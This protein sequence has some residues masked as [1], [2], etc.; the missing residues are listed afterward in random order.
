MEIRGRL[1]MA[2]ACAAGLVVAACSGSSPRASSTG[3]PSPQSA[4]SV[5][6]TQGSPTSAAPRASATTGLGADLCTIAVLS[7]TLGTNGAAAGTEYQQLLFRNIGASPCAL[8]GYPGVS[9]TD[10]AGRQ[11]GPAAARSN[12]TGQAITAVVLGAHEYAN[13]AVGIPTA[14]DYPAANC[15]PVATT[16]LRVFPPGSF[17]S[18]VVAFK[19]TVC[20]TGQ[21]KAL[22]TPVRAGRSSTAVG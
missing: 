22:V 19:T 13:A 17:Q 1:G 21:W 14:Q 20:T 5:P 18:V 8:V 16:G 3:S 10:A 9:F 6:S 12:V 7:V 4:A 15:H 2:A 11:V